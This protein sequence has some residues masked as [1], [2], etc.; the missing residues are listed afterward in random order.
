MSEPLSRASHG[1][2]PDRVASLLEEVSATCARVLAE[3]VSDPTATR[4]VA[5]VLGLSTTNA[6]R[7][8]RFANDGPTAKVLQSMPGPRAWQTILSSLVRAGA[9]ASAVAPLEAALAKLH[10]E[11]DR[12]GI[13]RSELP[14]YARRD[15]DSPLPSGDAIDRD[16][17][18]RTNALLWGASASAMA[19]SFLVR[20]DAETGRPLVIGVS[21][22]AGLRRIRPGPEWWLP[23]PD[24]VLFADRS[25]VPIAPDSRADLGLT[26]LLS[27]DA[28]AELGVSPE[29]HIAFRGE[30]ATAARP[31]DL[32][33]SA[34]G[35]L[36]ADLQGRPFERLAIFSSPIWIPTTEFMLEVLLE[37]TAA[38]ARRGARGASRGP[39]R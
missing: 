18:T 1:G 15:D 2:E 22:F 3:S 38:P 28:R 11:L 26:A 10:G 9:S 5:R 35:L 13:S 16:R 34:G 39:A 29:G 27:K 6:W 4:E 33:V 30:H 12:R 37:R 21:T 7:F 31:V 8:V 24:R 36:E 20:I 25:A 14:L 23:S 19:T 17:E 32:A